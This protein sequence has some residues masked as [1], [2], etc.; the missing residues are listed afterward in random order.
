MIV[1]TTFGLINYKKRTL[2]RY[3]GVLFFFETSIQENKTCKLAKLQSS[4]FATSQLR[5]FS[6]FAPNTHSHCVP[7]SSDLQATFKR[8]NIHFQQPLTVVICRLNTPMS[9]QFTHY[10]NS[11][12]YR[13]NLLKKI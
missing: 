8:E 11:L 13:L 6:F 2:S 10:F 9:N 12:K 1:L 4:N 7:T 5:K 3:E